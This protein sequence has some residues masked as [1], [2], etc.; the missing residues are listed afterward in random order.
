M[1]APLPCNHEQV[2]TYSN[3]LAPGVVLW[4]CGECR[5]RFY[6]HDDVSRTAPLDAAWAAAEAALPEGWRFAVQRTDEDF[7]TWAATGVSPAFF[8]GENDDEYADGQGPTPAAALRALA[9]R[10]GEVP[11]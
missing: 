9:A 8:E 4:A 6:P 5:I 7:G 10:L 2:I 1:T 3:A 11:R